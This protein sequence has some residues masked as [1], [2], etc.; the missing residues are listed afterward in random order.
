VTAA[1][2]GAWWA[3]IPCAIDP[4]P[5]TYVRARGLEPA[6]ATVT[7]PRSYFTESLA[8]APA[9]DPFRPRGPSDLP[10]IER[11]HDEATSTFH[12]IGRPR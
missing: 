8:P 10:P 2:F 6:T 4:H 1:S 12:P 7:F 11:L 3:G 9:E 5:P